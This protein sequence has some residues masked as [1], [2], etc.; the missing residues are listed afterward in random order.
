MLVRPLADSGYHVVAPDLV[1]FGH[2]CK[3]K[4]RKYYYPDMWAEQLLDAL[5][6]ENKSNDP[7]TMVGNSIGSLA[8]LAAA[9]KVRWQLAQCCIPHSPPAKGEGNSHK[10]PTNP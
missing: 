10:G 8:C 3:P 4:G 6:R 1:G 2:S 7:A 5:G 9:R